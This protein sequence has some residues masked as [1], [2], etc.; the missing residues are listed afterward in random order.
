MEHIIVS[1]VMKHMDENKILSEYQYGFRNQRSC[2]SQIIGLVHDLTSNMD[3]N[4]QTDMIVLD[5]A[6]AFDK[7]SH[8]RLLHKLEHYG[9]HG[10]N[11][12]WIKSFLN[13]RTQAV[14]LENTISDN[15]DVASGVP[16]GS[17]LG[18]VLFLIYINDITNNITSNIR[19]FADDCTI[20]RQIR[21]KEDQVLLQNDLNKLIKW[22]GKWKMAFNVDKCNVMHITRARTTKK[23]PYVMH[24]QQLEIVTETDYLGIT[25]SNNLSWN[26]HINN[27]EASANQAQGMLWRNIKK[28]PQH[29]KAM[30]VNTLIR[31]KVEYSSAVWDPY[32]KE[33]IDKIER[34]Q[35]RA[36]RYVYNNYDYSS[37]VT[38]MLENLKWQPLEERRMNTRLCLLYKAVNGLVAIPVQQYLIPLNRPS[39]HSNSLSFQLFSTRHDYFKYSFFPRTVVQWNLLPD[40][41]VKAST[42]DAFR[43]CIS[44]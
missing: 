8:P 38:T 19:L 18:P 3:K 20:Y 22:E 28:A 12:N 39:R 9:I 2:E 35:R 10:N 33:N 4:Y 6:K 11:K 15:V 40:A 31:P 16:Q 29:T 17:V 27:I 44:A 42:C 1:N 7:V 36:A 5:F 23:H 37:S 43:A 25:I 32:T 26:N 21:T 24:D 34:V 14:A 13:N 41:T 30:A